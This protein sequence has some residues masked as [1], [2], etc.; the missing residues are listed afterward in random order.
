M[1]PGRQRRFLACLTVLAAGIA[2]AQALLGMPDLALYFAPVFVVAGL[3]L[4]G[5]FVGE[6]RIV[7]RRV[8]APAPR[9][10]APHR[11]PRPAAARRLA[12]LLARRAHLERGPPALSL[13]A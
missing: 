4:S 5:R 11:L 7:A 3:V 1:M 10:R 8:P 13:A 6:E 12:S 9:R 2:A